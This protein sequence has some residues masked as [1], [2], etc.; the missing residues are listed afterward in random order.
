[1]SQG[2]VETRF[3]ASPISDGKNAVP[4]DPSWSFYDISKFD[5]ITLNLIHS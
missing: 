4:T 3:F 5:A 2:I 1:M